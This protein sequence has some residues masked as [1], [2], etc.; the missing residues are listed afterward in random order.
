MK[1]LQVL[2]IIFLLGLIVSSSGVAYAE[3]VGDNVT[4]SVD[5]PNGLTENISDN[6]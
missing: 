2:I 3:G 1:Y 6:P 5:T 4:A